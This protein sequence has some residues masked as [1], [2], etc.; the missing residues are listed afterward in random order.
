MVME[1]IEGFV[2]KHEGEIVFPDGEELFEA[3]GTANEISKKF[4]DGNAEIMAVVPRSFRT[5]KKT[6]YLI[7]QIVAC[8]GGYCGKQ[9][10]AADWETTKRILRG[11]SNPVEGLEI[12]ETVYVN[13][14][15]PLERLM[16]NKD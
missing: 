8:N 1:N 2:L 11:G 4:Y 10:R 15:I 3:I 14:L 12:A 16:K 5:K 6:D 9:A 13:K 7:S